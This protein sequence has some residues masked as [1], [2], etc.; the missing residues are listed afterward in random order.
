MAPPKQTK[1]A[2]KRTTWE[3][4]ALLLVQ[5]PT[6]APKLVMFHASVKDVLS[7]ATVEW[8]GPQSKGLQREQ[9]G[10]KVEAIAEFLVDKKNVIPTA[11]VIAFA[12]GAATVETAKGGA[13][14][15]VPI[16]KLTVSSPGKAIASVVDGQHRLYGMNEFDSKIRVPI[17]GI[18]DA[19]LVERAFQFLVV[20]NKASKVPATHTKALLADMKDTELAKRLQSAKLAFDQ[21]GI[22]DVDLVNS[23]PKSPFFESIEWTTTPK[24]KRIVQATAIEISLSYLEGLGLQ[25]LDDR[26]VR[27]SVFLEMWR[28]I[29]KEWPDLWQP[30]SR[31]VSKVGIICLTRF[32]ADLV[33]SWADNDVLGITITDLAQIA[34][35]T[36]KIVA[37]MDKKFWTTPWAESTKG[38]FDT[39]QGRDRVLAAITQLYRN[40]RKDVPWYTNIDIVDK[41]AA[42]K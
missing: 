39:T 35:Q 33:T 22:N 20:N 21:E 11:L 7:W 30:K 17:L 14:D 32:I 9:K 29:K 27:R 38:G 31:L 26:D 36:E 40:G 13:V 15:A 18:L 1:K 34:L 4:P 19:D 37:K 16:V 10:A 5:R 42:S 25:D 8:L 3:Y 6:P 12:K 2:K 28:T 24:E 41:A 23:D